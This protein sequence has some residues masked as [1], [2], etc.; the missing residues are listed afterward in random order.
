MK[1]QNRSRTDV[2]SETIGWV[3]HTS[4]YA[5]QAHENNCKK[6]LAHWMTPARPLPVRESLIA[7]KDV[8]RHRMTHKRF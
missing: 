1:V 5:V 8:K 6:F 2:F 7:L 3:E 4:S